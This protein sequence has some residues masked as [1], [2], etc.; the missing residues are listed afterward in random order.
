MCAER[1]L[2]VGDAA[3]HTNLLREGIASAMRGGQ[4]AADVILRGSLTRSFGKF[5]HGYETRC[6]KDLEKNIGQ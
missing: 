2:V 4:I 3:H 6:L 1:F 5:L